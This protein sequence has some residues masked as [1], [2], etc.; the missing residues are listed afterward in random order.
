MTI[1]EAVKALK[2][3]RAA[4]LVADARRDSLRTESF[5][6]CAASQEAERA[7]RLAQDELDRSLVAAIEKGDQ[8]TIPAIA[9]E[10]V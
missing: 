8:L 2:A 9:G 7:V 6:A 5:D 1:D 3:A 4:Q 10:E